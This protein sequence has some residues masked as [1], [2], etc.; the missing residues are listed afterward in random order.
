MNCTAHTLVTLLLLCLMILTKLDH[1]LNLCV[2][3]EKIYRF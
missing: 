3:L 1:L 2:S